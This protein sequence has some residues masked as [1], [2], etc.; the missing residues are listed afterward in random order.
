MK[1]PFGIRIRIRVDTREFGSVDSFNALV[2]RLSMAAQ[3]WGYRF[4]LETP[5]KELE[6][7]SYYRFL[8]VTNLNE[9]SEK[10]KLQETPPASGG[11][12]S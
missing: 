9:I 1:T 7:P 6:W 12:Q 2:E 10:E 11:S 5:I 4:E 8:V 3:N